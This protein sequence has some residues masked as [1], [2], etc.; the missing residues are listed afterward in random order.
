MHA[1]WGRHER[2]LCHGNRYEVTEEE[3]RLQTF[4]LLSVAVD[5]VYHDNC[6]VDVSIRGSNHWQLPTQGTIGWS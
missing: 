3:N 2:A 5:M 6:G 4:V 1:Q